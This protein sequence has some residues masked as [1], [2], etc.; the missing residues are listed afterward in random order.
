MTT[1]TRARCPLDAP[2]ARRAN[3]HYRSC[4][5]PVPN[6]RRAPRICGSTTAGVSS[7]FS[8][9]RKEAL[10]RPHRIRHTKIIATLGPATASPETIAELVRAGVDVFR[11]NFSHGGYESHAASMDHIRS[12]AGA[13]GRQVAILQDLSGPKIRIGRLAGGTPLEL[14]AGD[15]LRIAAGDFAGG[16]GRVS[17]TYAGLPG[18]VAKGNRLLLDDG[19]IELVVEGSDGQEITARVQNGGWLG[20]RKGINAPGVR[21][22]PAAPTEKDAQDLRF[23]VAHGVDAIA[24]SFVQSAEDVV[25]GR[26]LLASLGASGTRLIAKIERPGAVEDIDRILD[27]SDGV[28]VAR[29][30]LGL[31]LPLEHVPRVQKEITRAARMRGL[32]VIVATQVLESMRTQPRP[33]RAEVSDAA[34]AVDDGA[35]AIMLSGETAVGSYPIRTV[36]TLDAILRDAETLAPTLALPAEAHVIDL[37]HSRALCEAA[38]T[39]AASGVARAIVAVTRQGKTA[40]VLSAFRPR[41]PIFAVTPDDRIARPLTLHRGVTPM[42][43]ELGDRLDLAMRAIGGRLVAIGAIEPGDRLVL[44]SVAADLALAQANFVRLFEVSR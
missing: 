28:M 35:D 22:P 32:P 3:P 43:L 8:A 29:G 27:V 10:I 4:G 2:F 11:L 6:A 37:A 21:L 12:A 31:E 13:A 30:D 34:N 44:V 18:A 16:P 7:F 1:P 19:A 20:E 40:R 17:T 41:V 15:E 24:M 26:T 36:E 39:L 25:R 33:T 38:V 14:K 9:G 23:G 5:A 42:V